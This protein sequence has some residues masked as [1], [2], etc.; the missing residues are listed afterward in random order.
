MC[1]QGCLPRVLIKDAYSER[2][3]KYYTMMQDDS[4]WYGMMQD[5]ARWCIIILQDLL[6][7]L[8]SVLSRVLTND[9]YQVCF[10]RMF[11]KVFWDDARWYMM[12]QNDAGWCG[13]MHNDRQFLAR[14]AY[15]DAYQGCLPR[16]FTNNVY[17]ECLTKYC[18]MIW[19]N[20]RWCGMMQDDAWWCI[21][22]QGAY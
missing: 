12:M 17:P 10:S 16:M 9:V 20:S 18:M 2:L 6:E 13:M 7:C 1:Y 21:M 11:I 14:C 19:D 4:R 3:I 8:P 5:D 15:L 22:M